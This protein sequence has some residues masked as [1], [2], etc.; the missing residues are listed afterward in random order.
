MPMA[1]AIIRHRGWNHPATMSDVRQQQRGRGQ[2]EATASQ[3]EQA[4][5]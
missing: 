3:G 4:S 1:M 5:N 2:A